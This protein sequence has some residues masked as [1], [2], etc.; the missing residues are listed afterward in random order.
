MKKVMA[1]IAFLFLS[2]F[3]VSAQTQQPIRVKCGSSSS[4]TDS[5]GQVWAAD[6]G[7]N[8]G[9]ISKVQSP[10]L[11]TSDQELFENG[12]WGSSISPLVYNFKVLNGAYHVKLYFAELYQPDQIVGARVFNVKMQGN[13]VFPNLDVFAL[14]GANTALIKSA[15]IVVS[16][17]AAT[18]EFDNVKDHSKVTAIEILPEGSSP[19]LTMKF[20]HPDGTPVAGTLSYKM[21]NSF[22]NLNGNVA[23]VN[24]EATCNLISTPGVLGLAGQFQVHLTLTN[25]SGKTLWQITMD[26]NPAN[27]DFGAVQSSSLNVVVQNI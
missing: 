15:D 14:A 3:T 11:G 27:I 1:V 20:T 18:I 4:I 6:Y 24:G 8:S 12:R 22:V 7:F 21:S 17:G 25:S 13:M 9:E 19:S 2:S 26:M 23:L 5:K 10:V 16:N